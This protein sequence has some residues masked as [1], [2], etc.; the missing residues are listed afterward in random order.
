M[1]II[2][3]DKNIISHLKSSPQGELAQKFK[4]LRTYCIF[5][6]S[7]AILSDLCKGYNNLSENNKSKVKEDLD[8]INELSDK[9]HLLWSD[10][11]NALNWYQ[12]DSHHMFEKELEVYNE[13]VF[14]GF[15]SILNPKEPK[16]DIDIL[17]STVTNFLNDMEVDINFEEL[18]ETEEGNVLLEIF[19]NAVNTGKVI[20]FIR[21][22]MSWVDSLDEN[23]STYKDLRRIV[24]MHIG[25]HNNSANIQDNILNELD[26]TLM[27]SPLQKPFGDI[28]DSANE[29]FKGTLEDK[30][31]NEFIL[32]DMVG[33]KTDSLKKGYTN[34]LNDA[35]HSFIGSHCDF[36]ITEDNRTRDKAKAIY[37]KMN[38]SSKA[39]N[40]DE[41]LSIINAFYNNYSVSDFSNISKIIKQSQLLNHQVR[42]K[43]VHDSYSL[44]CKFLNFFNLLHVT[45][46]QNNKKSYTFLRRCDTHMR[47]ASLKEYEN[48]CNYIH[49]ILGEDVNG[50]KEFSLLES[51]KIIDKEWNGRQWN[52]NQNN[53]SIYLS[54]FQNETYPRL[55]IDQ[56]DYSESILESNN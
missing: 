1:L 18:R 26:K 15:D 21:D 51:Q 22:L 46:E 33:Y 49:S 12:N 11:Y 23:P 44:K 42:D 50:H 7:S 37:E 3:L 20:D 39:C 9:H 29:N 48:L 40:I 25:I 5:P 24:M 56:L 27:N 55:V 53:L 54:R 45:T 28:V 17:L 52:L 31:I 14:S 8:L 2:Y 34:F 16:D 36:F 38:V 47:I 43:I 10:E 30:F 13:S 35:K 41:F 19:P 32:L 4:E 6:Y